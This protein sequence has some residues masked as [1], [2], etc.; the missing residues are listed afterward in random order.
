[1]KD[2]KYQHGSSDEVARL[3]EI[4]NRALECLKVYG[5]ILGVE[6]AKQISE[7]LAPAPEET[8]HI[9]EANE[10]VHPLMNC[11]VCGEFR[12]HGHECAPATEEAINHTD[13]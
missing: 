3:R 5:G 11:Q 10:M 4:L 13:K 2:P 9:V 1:M 12:G 7:E 6:A 8:D